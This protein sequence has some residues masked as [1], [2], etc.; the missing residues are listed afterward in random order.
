MFLVK[1]LAFS[2]IGIHLPEIQPVQIENAFS[3]S[4]NLLVTPSFQ[5]F[6]KI[7]QPIKKAPRKIPLAYSYQDLAP[8]CKVEVKIEK[9]LKKSFKIRLGTLDYVNYLEQ[10]N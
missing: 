6:N 8:F 3:N 7:N 10:K 5:T 2:Q 4:S 9:A 1:N